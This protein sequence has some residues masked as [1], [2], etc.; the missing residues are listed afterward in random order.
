MD[1]L[2]ETCQISRGFTL[3]EVLVTL[4]IIGVVSAMTIPTLIQ[5][6]QRKVYV[7]QL[8]K[9]YNEFSQALEQYQ[10]DRNA[11]NL[12]EAGLNSQ[13]AC[14]NFIQ[15][16]MKSVNS[17]DTASSPCF[18]DSY[19]FLNGNTV[20]G[21]DIEHKAFVLPSGAAVRL[22]YA[23]RDSIHLFYM[24]DING[25]KEPNIQGRDLFFLFVYK[26]GLID[27]D[28]TDE[29]NNIAPLTK[30]A[31]ESIDCESEIG[32]CFGRILNDNWEMTY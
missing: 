19:K 13:E 16:Y 26:N 30:E 5:N 20:T 6:H 11:I 4:G 10:A 32:G 14:N 25:I 7:T 31:R 28:S 3:A 9:A 2:F 8:H 24:I 1:S 21:H 12:Q 22:K 17:C 18:A 15:T 23:N 29:V 27:D